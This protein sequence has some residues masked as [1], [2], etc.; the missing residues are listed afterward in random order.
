MF[1]L[2]CPSLVT[3]HYFL[4]DSFL[5]SLIFLSIMEK[6]LFECMS[7]DWSKYSSALNLDLENESGNYLLMNNYLTPYIKLLIKIN[8]KPSLISEFPRSDE[9]EDS[10]N[11]LKRMDLIQFDDSQDKFY[12]SNQGHSIISAYN[13]RFE[14][15]LKREDELRRAAITKSILENTKDFGNID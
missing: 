3:N 8:E 5:K 14:V 11:L 13:N 4:S 10:Y 9:K 15:K 7:E 12:I 2:I 1:C 6:T